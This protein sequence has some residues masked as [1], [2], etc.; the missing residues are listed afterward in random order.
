MEI[1]G[2]RDRNIS[3]TIARETLEM[4][5]KKSLIDYYDHL[6]NN[7]V[8]KLLK[9]GHVGILP[10]FGE[11]YGYSLLE[12]MASGCAVVST[13]LSPFNEL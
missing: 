1:E 7:E 13:F 8:L 6:P 4:I 9:A 12:A 5:K 10:S 11:T 3:K 2:Y